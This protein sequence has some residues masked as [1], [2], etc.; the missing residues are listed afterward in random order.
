MK[1]II[2]KSIIGCL[3]LAGLT[4]TSCDFLD[5]VPDEYTSESDMTKDRQA[6]LNY[7]YSCYGYL[8]Q[9]N[10]GTSSLDLLTGDEVVTAFEHETFAAFPK[11]NYTASNPVISY[12]NTLYQ[13][14]RQCFT[15]QDELNKG[16]NFSGLT[17]A[18]RADYK[19]QVKFLLGYYDFLLTRCY[20][21]IILVTSTPDATINP[22]NYLP[23]TNY[24]VCIDSICSYFDQAAAGLVATRTG[25]RAN[26]FGLATSVAA[27]AMKAKTLLYAAS[28]LFNGNSTFYADFKDKDGNALM[29]L[30]YDANKWVKARDAYKAAIDSAEA[31]GY[32]LYTRSDYKISANAY[33]S[34]PYVRCLRYMSTDYEQDDEPAGTNCEVIFAD[35]RDESSYGLQNKSMPYNWN[36]GN[37]AWNGI[38]PTIAML[39]RFYTKHGVPMSEDDS[40]DFSNPWQIVRVDS[41]HMNEAALKKQTMRFNLDREPRYYSWVA[42]ENGYY[43]IL[44]ASNNGAYSTGNFANT[45]SNGRITTGFYIGQNCSRGLNTNSLRSNNYSPTGFLNK[46]FVDPDII[47]SATGLSEYHNHPWPVIRLAELYLGYAE[48]CV[49]TGDLE[50]ARVYLNKVRTRAGLPTVE[51]AWSK[52]TANPNKPN[53]QDGLREIVRNERMNEFYLE[54]QNFWDM[55]RWL[56]A[57]KYFNVK[58]QGMNIE[59]TNMTNF[60]K[61]T[62][63]TFERKF[64]SPANYLMPIP[65]DDMNKNTHIVQN[66]GY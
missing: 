38:A 40:L 26:E 54:N 7:L 28:P 62:E 63:V 21:P 34:D 36:N 47:K 2:N 56:L 50:T 9:P 10:N 19:A 55:R 1:R 46:K 23:R 52:Y 27:L 37:N 64:T 29:P 15:F 13:G 31:A 49:E 4:L 65:S 12:W 41:A 11:G 5:V 32:H 58:A 20:G 30:T 14:I 17:D 3:F 25:T 57:E 6:A 42:F 22:S 33:P 39:N 18:D 44:S 24:D 60:A 8:P 43:E 51:E 61:P 45:Y 48:C 35:A 16:G 59:A 66:P 53:T